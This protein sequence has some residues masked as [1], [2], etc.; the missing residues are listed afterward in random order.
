MTKNLNDYIKKSHLKAVEK[1][2]EELK[3]W[4]KETEEEEAVLYED[5]YTS[6]TLSNLRVENGR[7]YYQ[8]D[9][10]DESDVVVLYDEDDHCYFET[11]YEGIMSFIK[12]YRKCLNKAK[13]YWAM[14]PDKLDRIQDGEEDDI[15]DEEND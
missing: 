5:A 7:I 1:F 13:K 11:E 9:G 10:R 15:E 12:F 8:Y 14:D 4:A 3:A 6:F 2:N